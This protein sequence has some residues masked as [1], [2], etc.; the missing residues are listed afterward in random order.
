MAKIIE[1]ITTGKSENVL[2]VFKK[3]MSRDKQEFKINGTP[4]YVSQSS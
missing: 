1:A 4:D 3:K 2:R